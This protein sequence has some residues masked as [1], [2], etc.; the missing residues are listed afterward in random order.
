MPTDPPFPARH[1]AARPEDPT[2][3]LVVEV[4]HRTRTVIDAELQRLARR[5]PSLGRA[6]LAV[7]DDAL[8]ELAECLIIGRLRGAK[9]D[10]VPLLKRLFDTT[11]AVS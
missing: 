2:S 4:H 1:R 5:V 10:A 9:Q 8:E 6:D 7:I 3:D 11:R